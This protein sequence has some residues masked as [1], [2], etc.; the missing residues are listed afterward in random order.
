MLQ[1]V[2]AVVPG[3]STNTSTNPQTGFLKPITLLVPATETTH[4]TCLRTIKIQPTSCGLVNTR[5][6]AVETNGQ[7][8]AV[9][10]TMHLHSRTLI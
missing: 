2:E 5:Q 9:T 3:R 4:Q 8:M 6:T 1:D 10:G 7:D